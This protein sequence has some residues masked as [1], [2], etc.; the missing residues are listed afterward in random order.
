MQKVDS[1]FGYIVVIIVDF[2][3]LYIFNNLLNWHIYFLLQSWTAPLLFINI[4]IIGRIIAT[5]IYFI[6]DPPWFKAL[7]KTTLNIVSFIFMLTIYRVFPFD[8]SV[9]PHLPWLPQ[10]VKIAIIISLSLTTLGIIVEF[11]SI[12]KPIVAKKNK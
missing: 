11:I 7:T 9:Y 3:L 4:S 8:F 5:S 1:K 2:I 12:F 10:V 6:Y